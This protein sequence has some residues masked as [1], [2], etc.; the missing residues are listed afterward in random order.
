LSKAFSCT[1]ADEWD[2]LPGTNN[3]VESINRQSMPYIVKFIS[4]RPLVEHFYLDD[5]RQVVLQI[6]S[7]AGVTVSYK[8]KK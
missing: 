4:L 6:A 7:E 1:N 2:E 5:H 8:A 3:P